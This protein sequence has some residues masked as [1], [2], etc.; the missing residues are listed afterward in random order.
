MNRDVVCVDADDSMQKAVNLMQQQAARMLVVMKGRELVGVVTDRDL[1]RASASDATSLEI[2]ELFY[3]ISRIRIKDIMTPNVITV[4]PD[5]TLEEVA[6][7]LFMNTISGA[8]VVDA[9]GKVVGTISQVEIFMALV[10]LS[11]Y[12]KQ[13][14]QLAFRIEDR[15][16]SIKEVTDI[17]REH[18]G[19]LASILTATSRAP[20]G[21][22]NLY[23]RA[24][25]IVPSEVEVLLDEL[26]AAAIL[27]YV[28]DHQDNNR[29]EYVKQARA[30]HSAF[31]S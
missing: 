8:P 20:A 16:G 15:P 14:L 10:T 25:D 1:K 7:Q 18:G 24:Y 22:R 3:L 9:E 11:G 27:L 2:H 5:H 17:I 19:R 29:I 23:I 6:A 30:D 12:G 26:S 28:V 21:Y 4:Q 13:G 31:S